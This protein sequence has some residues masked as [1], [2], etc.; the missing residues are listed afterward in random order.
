MTCRIFETD[1]LTEESLVIPATKNPED[2]RLKTVPLWQL[3]VMTA[4]LLASL[5]LV[6]NDA[7]SIELGRIA[8][9]L[10]FLL[11]EHDVPLRIQLRLGELG[12]RNLQ[13]F[14]VWADD[15][16]GIRRAFS[17]NVLNEAE[18]GLTAVQV[19]A[20]RLHANQTLA[21][22]MTASLRSQ[23]EVRL[24]TDAKLLRL[25]TLLTRPALIALRQ[26][27]EQAHGRVPDSVFPCA[28]MLEKRL[29]EV[30]EGSY[31]AQPL[32]DVISV[33]QSG[34]EYTTIQEV[35]ASVKVRRAPKAIAQPQTTEELR[36]R[37]ETMG[38]SYVIASYK[39]ANRLWIRAATMAVWLDYVK[40]L[41]SDKIANFQLDQEGI[42]I[43]ASWTTVLGYDL[44]MRK[45]VVRKV[46]YDGF[47][48]EAAL[49]FAKEDLSCKEQYFITPTA[50]LAAS[51]RTAP[52][53]LPLLAG[54]VAPSK[55][56]GKG[57]EGKGSAKK[58]KLEARAQWW[59]DNPDGG[60]KGKGGKGS[61][62]GKGGKGG[63]LGPFKKTP[64]GRLICRFFNAEQGCTRGAECGY[65]NVCSKCFSPEHGEVAC[66]TR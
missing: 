30:E 66:P 10:L 32:T 17:D 58:R 33:E 19:G 5:G 60:P 41:L 65:V 8:S 28:A 13:I 53:P 18:A 64:D 52:S 26:R 22:W 15:R 27:F 11:S 45:L 23:E 1:A 6:L 57:G 38:I 63:K 40:Y 35:G 31:S 36:S 12:Y 51:R 24:A 43:R 44:A 3:K 56:K 61:G 9:D 50:M 39:H 29:E 42:S 46:L 16:A 14:S 2:C 54:S 49:N 20:V 48:F 55:G 47:D 62:K 21:A 37:F 7:E 59:N 34:D 25:P 4:V